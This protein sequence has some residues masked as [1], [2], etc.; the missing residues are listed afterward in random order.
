MAV[1]DKSN[2]LV[3][4]KAIKAATVKMKAYADD[5][6]SSVAQAAAEAIEEHANRKDNPHGVTASQTGALPLTGGKLTGNLTGQYITGTWLQATVA[7][8]MASKPPR[9]CVQDSAGWIYSRTPDQLRDDLGAM[10]KGE[11]IA[12]TIPT[13]GWVKDATYP[14]YPYYYDIAVSGITAKDRVGITISPGSIDDAAACMICPA[15][16]TMA[17]KIRIWTKT[18]PTAAISAEYWLDQGKE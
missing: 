6:I 17:D 4:L 18:V 3:L 1:V 16:N 12:V 2:K 13:T 5:L 9:V 11:S 15:N 7:N 14:K 8:A 10:K